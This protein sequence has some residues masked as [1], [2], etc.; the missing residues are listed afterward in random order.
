MRKGESYFCY[1]PKGSGEGKAPRIAAIHVDESEKTITIDANGLVH[2]IYATDKT[3]S[4]ASS[5]R[6]TVVGIGDTFS[7]KG[8]Q[9]SYVRALITN[10]YGETCTQPISF[11]DV[12][13]TSLE[14]ISTQSLALMLYP[15]PASAYLNVFM[16]SACEGEMIYVYDLHGNTVLTHV[17]EGAQTNLPVQSL[18]AGMYIVQVGTRVGKFF[19]E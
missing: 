4:S 19:K 7:Y 5:A 18:G 13:A 2:W 8:Y 11:K 17:V 14:N 9:G 16:N 15:N 3:S 1:E 6:S 12:N 10:M